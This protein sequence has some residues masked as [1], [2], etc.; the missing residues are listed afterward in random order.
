MY[1]IKEALKKFFSSR[2]F[3]LSALMILMFAA[4][5]LRAFSLQIIHGES[6]QENFKMLIK[7]SLTI[8]ATRGNIYDCNGK[9]LAYNELAYSVSIRGEGLT[10]KD[11]NAQIAQVLKALEKNSDE[12]YNN[13]NIDL[14]EDGTYSFNVSGAS[15]KRFLADVFG[16]AYYDDLGYNTDFGFNE[17]N[18]TAEQVMEYL[19]DEFR[20]S[21]EKSK[22]DKAELYPK[23]TAYQIAAVRYSMLENRFSQY[24]P[25]TIAKDVSEEMVAYINEH[26][27]E[28]DGIMVEEDTI[29]K[30]NDSIYFASLIGYT[31]KI[32]TEEYETLHA[33]DVSYTTNDVIGKSGLEQYYESYLRGKNGSEEVYV[34]NVGRISEVIS[35]TDSVAGNDLYLSIDADLQKAV[36]Q[37]LEQEIAGII[38]SKIDTGEIPLNDVYFALIDNNV[39]NIENFSKENASENEKEIFQAFASAQAA[40]VALVEE[41]LTS[42]EALENNKMSE[43]LLDYF[44]YVI[45]LLKEDSVLLSKE[46]DETDEVYKKWRDGNISPREYLEHCIMKKWIDIGVI[47]VEDQYADT[48]EIYSALCSYIISDLRTNKEFSKLIYKYMLENN[49]ISGHKLCLIL[50]DQGTLNSD[51][52]AYAALETGEMQPLEFLCEKVKNIEI[53]PAQLALDPC[54]GSCVITDVKTGEI[55]ALVSYP[56]FDN[57]RLAN[58]VDAEYFKGLNE[59]NS[60]PQYNYATQERTAPGSTFK[61]VM[62]TAGF[63]ENMLTLDE[64]IECTGKFYEVSNEPQCWVYPGSHGLLNVSEALRDSCNCFFYTVGYKLSTANYTGTYNDP[65][66]IA[67]I[68]KYASIY[69]LNE[70]SGIEI[71]ENTPEIATQYPVMAAI[72]Q[73]NNNYTTISLSRYVTA[74]SSGKLYKYQLMNKIVAPDGTVMERYEPDYTDISTALNQEQWGAIHSGMRMVCEDMKIFQNFGVAVAGKTGTAQ[75]VETRPNH[76]LFVGYAPYENPEISIAVRIAYGYTSNNSA[77]AARNIISYYYGVEDAGQLLDGQAENVESSPN[78][79]TD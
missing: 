3:V 42:Q 47:H 13:F 73:S 74:V 2:L 40:A 45:S 58:G 56:S 9:L 20:M 19:L 32:D 31:G 33:A 69:G 37:L 59:D 60:N 43:E 77:D 10:D 12:L 57:N 23:E 16:E 27:Y 41:Q 30:Y 44:T 68:Q 15:L 48:S 17:A 66:G 49:R 64:Q 34:D 8:N 7:K 25:T 28:L 53:T 50:F 67:A 75:Q 35:H 63:S 5:I 38:H 76:A 46:I 51:A 78:T 24:K 55:R 22:K 11:L 65:N 70:K 14:L 26:S 54:T 52:A 39:I 71:A 29:R 61:M 18:A 72:G 62:A 6:Y 4:V 36:Y 1:D 79:V 21:E